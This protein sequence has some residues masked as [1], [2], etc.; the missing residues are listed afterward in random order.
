M[1]NMNSLIEVAQ[2]GRLVGLKGELKLHLHCDFPEQFKKG[3][4]FLTPKNETLEV[5]SYNA[6]R[7]LISFVGYQSREVAAKLVNTLLLTTQENSLKECHLE[8]GE[9]FWFDLIGA[10]VIDDG[11][12]LGIVH[13]IERIAANDYLLID[14]DEKLIKTGLVRS[15]YIPYIERYIVSFDKEKKE[16]ITQDGLGILEN[17]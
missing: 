11:V 10:R 6:S 2:L 13:E 14:T 3:K 17:S 5:F 9:Y 4:T 12:C 1:N 8:E 16:I 15:F 7:G